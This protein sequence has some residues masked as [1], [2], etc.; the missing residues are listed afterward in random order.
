MGI[1]DCY[2]A[3]NNKISEITL[4]Q[5]SKYQES[6]MPCDCFI[7]CPV[8]KS[9]VNVVYDSMAPKDGKGGFEF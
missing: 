4:C 2:D 8:R 6:C 3:L 7:E 5:E 9:Y 1:K